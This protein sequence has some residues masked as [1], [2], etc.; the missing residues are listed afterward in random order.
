MIAKT[1][2]YNVKSEECKQDMLFVLKELHFRC[3]L[4][5]EEY[6]RAVETVRKG[7]Y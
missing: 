1:E 2:G 5:E 3:K 4:S 6:H 7:N